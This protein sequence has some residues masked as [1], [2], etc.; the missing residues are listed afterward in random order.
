MDPSQGPGAPAD[1]TILL[2]GSSESGRSVGTVTLRPPA[3]R[4]SLGPSPSLATAGQEGEVDVQGLPVGPEGAVQA[5]GDLPPPRKSRRETIK[6]ALL[7]AGV[8]IVY[9]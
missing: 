5:A 3:P 7:T 1:H 4:G 9:G 8:F 2:S 6:A